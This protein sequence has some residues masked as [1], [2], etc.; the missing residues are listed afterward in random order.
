MWPLTDAEIDKAEVL[1]KILMPQSVGKEW[2]Y[3]MDEFMDGINKSKSCPS[4]KSPLESSNMDALRRYFLYLIRYFKSPP[5]EQSFRLFASGL[6]YITGRLRHR[7]F[8]L[9]GDP[10]G[11]INT[12]SFFKNTNLEVYSY[13]KEIILKHWDNIKSS[14]EEKIREFSAGKSVKKLQSSYDYILVKI[15]S[16]L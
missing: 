5:S 10:V 4:R 8:L 9:L 6:G 3:F 1:I 16:L 7:P 14:M 13:L 11:F 12:I 15:P 2:T